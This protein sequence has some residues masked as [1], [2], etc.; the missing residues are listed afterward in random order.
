VEEVH[1]L[2]ATIDTMAAAIEADLQ[3]R[4]Q[5]QQALRQARARAEVAAETKPFSWPT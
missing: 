2:A 3:Q 4:E 1:A 5:V